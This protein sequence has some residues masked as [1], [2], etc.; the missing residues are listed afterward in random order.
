MLRDIVFVKPIDEYRL[1]VRFED[2]VE[3]LYDVGAN[4]KF[5]GIFAPL[6]NPSYFAQVAVNPDTGTIA[7]PNGAD[8]DPV[9]IYTAVTGQALPHAVESVPNTRITT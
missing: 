5:Q 2:D 9:V 7:W 3:G 4:I 8:L 1:I 6:G